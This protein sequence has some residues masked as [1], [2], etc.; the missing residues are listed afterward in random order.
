MNSTA[1][2]RIRVC[3][4]PLSFSLFEEP[5]QVVVVVDVLRATSAICSAFTH[6]VERM[7]PISTLEEAN[8]LKAK[9]MVVAAER[10]GEVMPGFPLGN[11]PLAYTNGAYSGQTIAITT[12]NGTR[13]IEAAKAA[14]S[15]L[16][17]AFVNINAVVKE[18]QLLSRPVVVLCAGWKDRF[19]LEDTLFAGAVVEELLASLRF[20]TDCDSARAARL[21]YLQARYDLFGFLQ[22]SS[23]RERLGRL[24]LEDDIRYCLT[25]NQTTVVP[26][27]FEGKYLAL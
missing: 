6:G 19:N 18:L 15:V 12:T 8:A 11:S 17:G 14:H 25:P 3:F 21:L 22:E 4:S 24:H 10:N 16:I 13:A 23:H 2:P 26:K 27:L 7:I 1:P 5:G 9:G 20:G